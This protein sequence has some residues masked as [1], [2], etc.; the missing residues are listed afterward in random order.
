MEVAPQDHRPARAPNASALPGAVAVELAVVDAQQRRGM[1]ATASPTA[2]GV[3][4]HGHS[5]Q[6]GLD[7]GVDPPTALTGDD[8]QTIGD[9]E[10]RQADPPG[11]T[12]PQHLL[13]AAAVEHWSL[14]AGCCTVD[15]QRTPRWNDHVQRRPDGHGAGCERRRKCDSTR[16]NRPSSAPRP[17]RARRGSCSSRKRPHSC[18]RRSTRPNVSSELSTIHTPLASGG[19][20]TTDWKG[21]IATTAAVAS[22]TAITTPKPARLRLRPPISSSYV[23]VST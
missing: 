15:R 18:R 11:T 14:G 8:V 5:E 9:H 12:E 4:T 6:A 22:P 21:E 17:R 20:A 16:R 1:D 13:D 23:V 2:A 3:V 19:A 7:R 10:V